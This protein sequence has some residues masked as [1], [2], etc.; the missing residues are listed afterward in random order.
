M[1]QHRT[2]ALRLRGEYCWLVRE[3]KQALKWWRKSIREGERLGAGLELARTHFTVGRYL[4]TPQSPY[5][6]LDGVNAPVYLR[7]AQERFEA[8]GLERDLDQLSRLDI[9]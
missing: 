1:A 3:P 5:Q 4:L 6:A 9:P 8:M 7:K 2:E